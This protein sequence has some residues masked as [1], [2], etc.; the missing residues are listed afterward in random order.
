MLLSSL[1]LLLLVALAPSLAQASEAAEDPL[2]MVEEGAELGDEQGSSA[3]L[4][5]DL[6]HALPSLCP[7]QPEFII[8]SPRAALQEREGRTH[9]IPTPPPRSR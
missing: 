9:P 2:T 3:S 5:D 1:T 8:W 4:D 7:P 6:L